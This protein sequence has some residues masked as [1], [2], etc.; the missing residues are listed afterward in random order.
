MVADQLFRAGAWFGA[1][2]DDR[3]ECR[4]QGVAGKFVELCEGVGMEG[5]PHE[6]RTVCG[7]MPRASTISDIDIASKGVSRRSRS[8]SA[9]SACSWRRS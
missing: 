1:Q 5:D 2:A 6:A 3:P 9:R 7:S 8:A 4:F